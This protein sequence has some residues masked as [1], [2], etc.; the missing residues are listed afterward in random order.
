MTLVGSVF[1]Q[2]YKFEISIVANVLNEA[3]TAFES[4]FVSTMERIS[5][6]KVSGLK[7]KL[8]IIII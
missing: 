6:W 8:I 2:F 3:S 5:I 7:K 4:G 1:A